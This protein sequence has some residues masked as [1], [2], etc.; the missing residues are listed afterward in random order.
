MLPDFPLQVSLRDPLSQ[1]T[2]NERRMLLAISVLSIFIART[3]LVPTKISALGIDLEK[4]DQQ[5]FLLVMALVV[6]YFVIAFVLYGMTDFLSWRLS[7]NEGSKVAYKAFFES[8]HGGKVAE[9]GGAPDYYPE[10]W[11]PRWPN[12]LAYPVSVAR[13]LFEFFF[14]ILIAGYAIYALIS[15]IK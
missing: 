5:A 9:K 15:T 4:T 8:H 2:R 13:A 3:G 1:V 12:H 11:I 14:P 7:Y 10:D 6:A